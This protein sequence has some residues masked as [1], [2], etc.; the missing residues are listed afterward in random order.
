MK[1]IFAL[2]LVLSVAFASSAFATTVS[3][4]TGDVAVGNTT[5]KTSKNVYLF[6]KSAADATGYA[7]SA[8]HNKGTKTFGSSSGDAKVYEFKETAKDC[9]AAPVGTA[10]ADFSAWTSL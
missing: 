4:L 8:Y 3:N 5:V 9:P 2:M 7:A 6:Y 10:S 1:K